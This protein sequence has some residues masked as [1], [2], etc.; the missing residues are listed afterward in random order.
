[1]TKYKVWYAG[2]RVYKANDET[3]VRK[4]AEQDLDCIPKQFNIAVVGV[5][6]ES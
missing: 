5:K 1:M 2:Y 4:Y 3:E 6:D